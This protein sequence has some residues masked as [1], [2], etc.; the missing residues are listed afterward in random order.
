MSDFTC[1]KC[2]AKIQNA[3]GVG[4]PACGF[5]RPHTH[6]QRQQPD[7]KPTV[8]APPGYTGKLIT[9]VL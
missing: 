8:E 5:G 2:T 4:C 6:E 3:R 9:E 7:Q 1:P